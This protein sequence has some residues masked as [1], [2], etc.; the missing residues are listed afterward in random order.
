VVEAYLTEYDGRRRAKQA[1]DEAEKRFRRVEE[2]KKVG[3]GRI[4]RHYFW[5]DRQK[6]NPGICT[7]AGNFRHFL[8]SFR[9]YWAIWGVFWK[10]WLFFGYMR[11]FSG[12]LPA[13][14][15][16]TSRHNWA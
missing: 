10:F 7:H 12:I 4:C 6:E 9:H 2:R 16:S 8:G 13:R 11:N 15:L 1:A 14:L 3:S 5:H